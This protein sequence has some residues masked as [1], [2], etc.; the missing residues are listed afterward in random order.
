MCSIHP[1]KD[2]YIALASHKDWSQ[3]HTAWGMVSDF[4]AV[5]AIVA[6][7]YQEHRHEQYGTVMRMLQEPV[8]FRVLLA[9]GE[10]RDEVQ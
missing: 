3:A 8:P 5:D 1:T 4:A 9:E 7:K 10:G 6:Q 2:F